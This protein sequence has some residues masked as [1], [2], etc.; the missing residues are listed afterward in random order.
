MWHTDF[1][2]FRIRGY[3]KFYIV[4]VRTLKEPLKKKWFN[5]PEEFIKEVNE[6]VDR[7]NNKPKEF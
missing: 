4:A 3:G 1:T 6:F 5:N 7:Y 2:E